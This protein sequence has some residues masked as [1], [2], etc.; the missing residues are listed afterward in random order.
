MHFNFFFQGHAC[1]VWTSPGQGLNQSSSFRPTPQPQQLGIQAS[2]ATYTTAH[3]NAESFNPLS[4][5]RDRTCMLIDTNWVF[6]TTEPPREPLILTSFTIVIYTCFKE[7]LPVS[8]NFHC[9]TFIMR[10]QTCNLRKQ[11]IW[12]I[13]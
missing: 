1:G 11:G 6:F 8:H 2:S 9:K 5:A 4:K 10:I 3:V 12:K 7:Q 13:I